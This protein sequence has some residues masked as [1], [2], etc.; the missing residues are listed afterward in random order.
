ML[1]TKRTDV[2][3][4]TLFLKQ[5]HTPRER[6]MK[7]NQIQF[8]ISTC[9]RS[10]NYHHALHGCSRHIFFRVKCTFA[11]AIRTNS[12]WNPKKDKKLQ[13]GKTKFAQ[14]ARSKSA[15]N[16]FFIKFQNSCWHL[17]KLLSADRRKLIPLK[18]EVKIPLSQYQKQK[19]GQQ[20]I[21]ICLVVQDHLLKPN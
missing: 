7:S 5:V 11:S 14:M 6:E 17:Q 8:R 15:F 3:N 9:Q 20:C 18:V 13:G 16:P 10:L 12:G 4:L 19:L 1:P 21:C 2:V